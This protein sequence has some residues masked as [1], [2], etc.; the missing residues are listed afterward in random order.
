MVKPKSQYCGRIAPTPTGYL[1]LG[2]GRTFWVAWK[3]ARERGGRLIF[4]DEDLDP[5]RCLPEY[6]AAALEDCRWL[7]L[8]WD[9]G[10]ESEPGGPPFRQS[11]RHRQG[12][13]RKAWRR[14]QQEGFLY[15]C[16]RSRREIA[17]A[18]ASGAPPEDSP[19][20]EPL[21]PSCWRPGPGTGMEMES[22][23]ET[24]WRF[25]VPDGERIEFL[26]GFH[27]KTGAKAGKD[28]G[29]FLVWRKNGF[30]S[31]ELAVVVDDA[32]MG[33]TE[34]VRGADLLRSTARQLL[35]YRALNLVAPA[36]FHCP[37]VRDARGRRLAKRSRDLGLRHLRNQGVRAETL[38]EQFRKET[39]DWI[40][41]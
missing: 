41:H 33:I 38:Q 19:D 40:S 1:H 23:G 15:P 32:D 5:D 31:Y 10:P 25:R 30:P 16:S 39:R 8:E 26:D 27:G 21:Y 34:V 12:F 22:P 7:G 2:H 14:L 36:Y 24:N 3:R 9:L 17:E 6:S 13:Y 18:T 4:R 37:L 28:F 20:E 11:E 35:L 29:D